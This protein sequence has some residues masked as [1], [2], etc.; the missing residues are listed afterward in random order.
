MFNSYFDI[1]RG[2]DFNFNFSEWA[3]EKMDGFPSENMCTLAIKGHQH[4]SEKG[5]INIF[6][7]L[8]KFSN[9]GFT[10]NTKTELPGDFFSLLRWAEHFTRWTV[11]GWWFESLWKITEVVSWD[12]EIPN[13][14]EYGKI[15]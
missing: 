3:T 11:A 5:E 1:T 15:H 9:L 4:T 8:P 12:D 10:R 2:S 7:Q 6:R 14:M 13:W